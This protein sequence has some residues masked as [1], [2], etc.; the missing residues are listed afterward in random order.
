VSVPVADYLRRL[1]T[2]S[3]V[4]TQQEAA[5][6]ATADLLDDIDALHQPTDGDGENVYCTWC[7]GDWP[8]P[9]ARLLHSEDGGQ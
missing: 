7:V 2:R 8:C 5:M 4:V 3:A 9:T 6:R 1:V